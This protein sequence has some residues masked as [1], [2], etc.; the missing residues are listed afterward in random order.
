MQG[1]FGK[2]FHVFAVPVIALGNK[3]DYL[4]AAMSSVLSLRGATHLFENRTNEAPQLPV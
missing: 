4:R 2:P 3:V 1:L